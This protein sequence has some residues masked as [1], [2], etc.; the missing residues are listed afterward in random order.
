[1]IYYGILCKSRN[2][3]VEICSRSRSKSWS[4]SNDIYQAGF[5]RAWI[6][7]TFA[8]RHIFMPN[9]ESFGANEYR[10][11]RR[12]RAVCLR[13]KIGQGVVIRQEDSLRR[14][15]TVQSIKISLSFALI[16]SRFAFSSRLTT[17]FSSIATLVS[18]FS[19]KP[20]RYCNR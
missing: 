7:F 4:L 3:H 17:L 10:A 14:Q 8:S 20:V 1:M 13:E 11:E 16:V 19:R 6:S 18:R 12:V 9:R 2:R 15:Q 5:T